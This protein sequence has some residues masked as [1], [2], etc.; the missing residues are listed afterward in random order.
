M[1]EQRVAQVD[2]SPLVV[3]IF[4]AV[5]GSSLKQARKATEALAVHV[6]QRCPH[7]DWPH[8]ALTVYLSPGADNPGAAPHLGGRPSVTVMQ[9]M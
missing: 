8:A 7:Y 3:G 4:F 1:K 5:A 2:S 6:R 9:I